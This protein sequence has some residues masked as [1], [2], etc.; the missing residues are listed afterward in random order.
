MES[1]DIDQSRVI[2]WQQKLLPF[3]VIMISALTLF[4]FIASCFQLYY[5]HQRIEHSPELHLEALMADMKSSEQ[6]LSGVDKLT[7]LKWKTMVV[8][9]GHTLQR[10]YHQANVLLMS[11]IWTRYLGFV[12]GMI[13]ALVGAVFV[14]GKIRESETKIDAEHAGAKFALTTASPGLVIALL[15]TIL[16]I[17]T[18][19][20]HQNIEVTDVPVYLSKG[21]TIQDVPVNINQEMEKIQKDIKRGDSHEK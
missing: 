17:T 2:K 9:E 19:V 6:T 5:L 16:M 14:L 8:L 13:L 12:T 11:R 1:P 3:M 18:M 7:S 21:E 4:F 20:L 15:G 10:R